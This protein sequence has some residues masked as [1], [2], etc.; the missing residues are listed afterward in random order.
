MAPLDS[1][2]T[3][4]GFNLISVQ[5]WSSEVK[6]KPAKSACPPNSNIILC[7]FKY[8]GLIV[9]ALVF[10]YLMGRKHAQKATSDCPQQISTG[11]QGSKGQSEVVRTLD[12]SGKDEDVSSD[13]SQVRLDQC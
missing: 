1:R 10:A 13:I 8:A 4:V 12:D 5:V 3:Q 11:P 2:Y 7:A 6:P 9:F